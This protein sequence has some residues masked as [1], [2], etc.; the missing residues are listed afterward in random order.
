MQFKLTSGKAILALATAALIIGILA[1]ACTTCFFNIPSESRRATERTK[2]TDTSPL[3]VASD[4]HESS[5]APDLRP[6]NAPSSYESVSSDFRLASVAPDMLNV[7]RNAQKTTDIVARE[8][9]YFVPANLCSIDYLNAR[10]GKFSPLLESKRSSL[11]DAIL[12]L[13]PGQRIAF[14]QV[15]ER[16]ENYSNEPE[17]FRKSLRRQLRDEGGPI[18]TALNATEKLGDPAELRMA[19]EAMRAILNDD[20][21]KGAIY[22]LASR[23]A[24]G[25]QPWVSEALP[26]ELRDESLPL[27]VIAVHLALC[28]SGLECGEGTTPRAVICIKYGECISKDVTSAYRNL[29]QI[30]D[31]S[32]APT[33]AVASRIRSALVSNAMDQLFVTRTNRN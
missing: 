2:P 1:F 17:D 9:A 20:P 19:R 8:L 4:S 23:I 29:F 15:T 6:V 16:C 5:N 7:Q 13:S 18:V 11:S 14:K 33:N 28:S 26:P 3:Q 10:E 12:Q 30:Y 32:F 27:S 25:V 22:I 31:V 24:W 21:S